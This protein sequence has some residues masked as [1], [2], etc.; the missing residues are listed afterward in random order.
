MTVFVTADP[1]Y[2]HYN[3][4]EY[5]YRPFK[6]IQEM[7]GT[8]VYNWNSIVNDNDMVFILGDFCLAPREQQKHICSLLKGYKILVMG[9]HDSTKARMLDIGFDEVYK[10]IVI[11]DR[12]ILTHIP[13]FLDDRITLNV[14][15]DMWNYMPIPMPNSKVPMILC[16]HVHDKWLYKMGKKDDDDGVSEN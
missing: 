7:N 13:I 15:V 9:N 1:H 16:G 2:Y 10:G 5:A 14:G 3:I 4:I 6:S 12:L 11:H 8:L